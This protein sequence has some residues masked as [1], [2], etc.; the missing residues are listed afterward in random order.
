MHWGLALTS[1][2]CLLLA[3]YFDNLRGPLLPIFGDLFKIAYSEQSLFL[4]LGNA[5]AV[6]G[7]LYLL[8]TLQR[9]GDRAGATVSCGFTILVCVLS[10]WVDRFSRMCV[11][12]VVLGIA[13]AALGALANVF[14]IQ[15]T[16]HQRRA[17]M[18][19]GLHMFYGFGSFLGP[20]S[21]AFFAPDGGPN[22]TRTLLSGIPL[23]ILL[24][25]FFYRFLK[26]HHHESRPRAVHSLT[27]VQILILLCFAI[28]VVGEVLSS[29]WLPTY[30]VKVHH[31]TLKE[32][33]RYSGLFFVVMGLSRFA[34][35]LSLK[36]E[37]ES[38]FIVGSILLAVFFS[39]LGHFG[40]S[41]AFIGMGV[42]GP[43]FPL[44]MARVSRSF[45]DQSA[46]LTIWILGFVQ[47]ALAIA[48]LTLGNL[49]DVVG[50]EAAYWLPP[51]F[52]VLTVVCFAVY[53]RIERRA[54]VGVASII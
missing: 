9:R 34:C 43:Y 35:F 19:C 14:L 3:S 42:F 13:I 23:V 51:A 8:R 26:R 24:L 20:S 4:V 15:A 25:A 18:F 28:Y 47:A 6:L 11:L 16:D 52:L 53:L 29:M 21:L 38:L 10:L 7:N 31:M 27:K 12:A 2:F 39:I 40:F 54:V 44:L 5:G 32:A 17:R 33:L 37:Q 1:F 48:H 41:W 46:R 22:W 45:P 50:I 49:S 30:L 36:Q